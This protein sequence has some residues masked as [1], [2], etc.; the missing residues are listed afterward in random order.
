[1]Q[2]GNVIGTNM[3]PA[4]V[5]AAMMYITV[6]TEPNAVPICYSTA[7]KDLPVGRRSSLD[8]MLRAF[9]RGG[10]T[11]TALPVQYAL[12]KKLDV[13]AIVSYTDNETWADYG[14]NRNGHVTQVHS[15]LE[16]R[17]GHEVKFV[18]CATTAT[19]CTDVDPNKTSMFEM[20]AFS[21]DTPR[22]ISAIINGD[23]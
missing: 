8:E 22:I 13:D 9:G 21:A 11:N 6:R 14:W 23:A 12:D 17:L 18:N 10:G 3:T 2:G 1:M 15:H 20:V 19:Q 4:K 7:Y 16:Q 5:A